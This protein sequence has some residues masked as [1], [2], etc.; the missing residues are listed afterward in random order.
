MSAPLRPWLTKLPAESLRTI[1]PEEKNVYSGTPLIR[2]PEMWAIPHFE[3]S[4]I[5]PW[6]VA[7]T[8][9]RTLSLVPRVASLEGFHCK[10]VKVAIICQ[11]ILLVCSIWLVSINFSLFWWDPPFFYR[12]VLVYY[13]YLVTS[14]ESDWS[15]SFEYTY[16]SIIILHILIAVIVT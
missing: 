16:S 10:Y 5:H 14:N 11:N 13:V 15:I 8:L 12:Y 7:T 9:I 1:V 2:T 4:Q 3:K 6:N